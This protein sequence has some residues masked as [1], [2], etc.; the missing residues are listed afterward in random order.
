M[1]SIKQLLFT[2]KQVQ[3][4]K[5]SLKRL[6]TAARIPLNLECMTQNRRFL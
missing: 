5:E 2:L 1:G 4:K 6:L 3:T